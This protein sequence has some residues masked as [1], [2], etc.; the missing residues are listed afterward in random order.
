MTGK[1]IP[2]T[3]EWIERT[4]QRMQEAELERSQQKKNTKI[5]EHGVHG[6]SDGIRSNPVEVSERPPSTD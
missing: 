6:D 3:D 4:L 5:G 1:M 2:G